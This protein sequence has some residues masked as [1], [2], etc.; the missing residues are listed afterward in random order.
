MVYMVNTNEQNAVIFSSLIDDL[1]IQF[2]DKGN[3][4]VES[5]LSNLIFI[6][7]CYNYAKPIATKLNSLLELWSQ[8]PGLDHPFFS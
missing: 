4:S 5:K 2:I 7:I 3:F 6:P 1:V 8:S